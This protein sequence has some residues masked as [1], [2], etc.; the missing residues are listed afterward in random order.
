MT[1]SRKALLVAAPAAAF[2]AGG[3]LGLGFVS[4]AGQPQ[5]PVKPAATQVRVEYRA[6]TT[7][8]AVQPVTRATQRRQPAR[9]TGAQPVRS[10]VHNRDH[11][12]ATSTPASR[13]SS[14]VTA[15]HG[16]PMHHGTAPVPSRP[17]YRTGCDDHSGGH[18]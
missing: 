6:V 2:V 15:H 18:H 8:Q 1:K 9:H 4:S 5:T 12:V 11:R 3:V 10:Q 16:E 7:Q 14:P 13:P 17:M